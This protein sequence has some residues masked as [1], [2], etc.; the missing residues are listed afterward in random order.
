MFDIILKVKPINKKFQ[1]IPKYATLNSSGI[2][3]IAA[4][5]NPIILYCYKRLLIPTGIV[6]EIPEG[7]EGQVR[8]RSGL[9][10]KHGITVL[11]SPGT[12][13]SDYRNEIG[14]I[15]I[16]LGSW[17]YTIRPGDRIAQ[18][19]ICP[20]QKVNIVKVEEVSLTERGVSGF[21]STGI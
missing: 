13:D 6:I 21:G 4:I 14:V 18:L 15:L 1:E 7:Y 10:L 17:P 2:D 11:N 20:V 5:E 16:N 9:A 8:P 3:L 19:V 12:I